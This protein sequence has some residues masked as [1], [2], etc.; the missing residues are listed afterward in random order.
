MALFFFAISMF[1]GVRR[2]QARFRLIRGGLGVARA[3]WKQPDR[4][5]RFTGS[6]VEPTSSG[7][8]EAHVLRHGQSSH[9]AIDGG[10]ATGEHQNGVGFRNGDPRGSI[11]ITATTLFVIFRAM[12]AA[13]VYADASASSRSNLL[14]NSTGFGDSTTLF[15]R[16]QQPPLVNLVHGGAFSV[17]A[18][19]QFM[20]AGSAR[21]ASSASGSRS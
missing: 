6:A 2:S 21:G 12:K 10:N 16:I 7:Q 19:P 3:V 4:F 13:T 18:R 1:N 14:T 8:R 9:R 11:A 20:I 17:A 15:L 5:S